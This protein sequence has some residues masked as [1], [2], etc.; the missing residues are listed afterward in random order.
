MIAESIDGL[1]KTIEAEERKLEFY[2]LARKRAEYPSTTGMFTVLIDEQK[3]HI[4]LLN[5]IQELI[6]KYGQWPSDITIDPERNLKEIFFN[7][8]EKIDRDIEVSPDET[9]V[10]GSSI[11]MENKDEAYYRERADNTDNESEKSL[12]LQLAERKKRQAEFIEDFYSFFNENDML[13]D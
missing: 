6:Y 9:I 4:R 5:S 2:S 11:E 7:A 8:T 3:K 10:M 1:I 13:Y 12:Y